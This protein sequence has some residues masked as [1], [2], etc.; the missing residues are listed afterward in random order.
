MAVVSLTSLLRPRSGGASV[1][2]ALLKAV[3]SGVWIVDAQGKPLMGVA[4]EGISPDGARIPVV[5]EGTPLG[6]VAGPAESAQAT[7]LL[8]EHFAARE[9]ER[10]ALAAEV[11][12]LY[13]E[14][15]LIG[16]LSEQLAA[17]LDI[18]AIG[19]SALEQA[20]RLI[21]AS[22]GGILVMA[23]PGAPLECTA[24]FGENLYG[25]TQPPLPPTSRFAASVIERGTAE[26][27]NDP[28]SDPRALDS[29]L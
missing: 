20:R 15:H 4:A 8:L 12:H 28:G 21:T 14:V 11:L 23:E 18:S 16:Q 5:F 10:R 26:I 7:A 19:Q 9:S 6:Y 2:A 24:C 17:V 25:E 13:R 1:V 22:N 3:G 29:E 27:V